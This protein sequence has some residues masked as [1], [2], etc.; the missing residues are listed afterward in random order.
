MTKLKLVR[1]P[2]STTIPEVQ[3][4]PQEAINASDR[5]IDSLELGELRGFP[6]VHVKSKGKP[7][8]FLPITA[9]LTLVPVEEEDVVAEPQGS[10]PEPT[11]DELGPPSPPA[12]VPED[13]AMGSWPPPPPPSKPGPASPDLQGL[14]LDE[15]RAVAKRR[16]VPHALSATKKELLIILDGTTDPEPTEGDETPTEEQPADEPKSLSAH[17]VEELRKLASEA[18]VPGYANMRKKQLIAAILEATAP[19][20]PTQG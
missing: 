3:S 6:G 16:G 2:K 17:T 10:D 1:F 7:S 5:S 18:K 13:P 14:E 4:G 19:K 9:F 11:E 20:E 15:L 8:V 12:P